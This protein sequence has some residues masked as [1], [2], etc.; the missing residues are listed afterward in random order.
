MRRIINL[1][2]VTLDG[3]IDPRDWASSSGSD[4]RAA[5]IHTE[6]LT[7][8]DA[9][10]LGGRTYESFAGVWPSMSGDSYSDR[11]NSMTKYVVSST[12]KDPQWPNTTV[13]DGDAVSTIRRL[14]ELSGGDI[15]QIGFGR[16]AH[17]LMANALLDEVQLW[18]HPLF[19]GGGSPTLLHRDGPTTQFDLVDSQVLN[20]GVVI[21]TYERVPEPDETAGATP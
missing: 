21:L 13:V 6:L 20:N 9:L 18:M 4:L 2:F 14:K 3:V 17:T 5:A 7:A 8:C 12:V 16:L 19:L 10:L 15:V 11:I 1:T